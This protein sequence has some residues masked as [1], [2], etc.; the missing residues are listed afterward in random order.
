MLKDRR[1]TNARRGLVL[2]LIGLSA[3][4]VHLGDFS[5]LEAWL[6][7]VATAVA[8]LKMANKYK[9]SARQRA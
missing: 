3:L 5:H 7:G 2:T 1:S 9:S 8:S 6:I 4:A